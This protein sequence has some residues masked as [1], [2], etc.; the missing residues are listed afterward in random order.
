MW[1][2]NLI[3]YRF[4]QPFTLSSEQLNEKLSEYH[5][6]PCPP[7]ATHT[8]G[9][10]SPLKGNSEQLVHNTNGCF[11]LNLRKEERILPATVVNE[12]LNEKVENI[13]H[14]QNRKVRRKEKLELKDEVIFE[15][16]PKAF[17]RSTW[18]YAY[19]DPN[20]HW[21]VVDASSF[22][23][24]EEFTAYLRDCIESLPLELIKAEQNISS[25]MTQWV[26]D[27]PPNN[28]EVGTECELRGIEDEA[29]VTRCKGQ[30]L[31][32]E[33]IYSHINSGKQVTKLALSWDEKI[34]FVLCAD[35]TIKRLKFADLL[36]EQA[37]DE[38]DGDAA[39]QFDADFAILNTET[40]KLINHLLSTFKPS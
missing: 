1:F 9:W 28:I 26:Q 20:N 15:L 37:F 6:S 4:T 34:D 22:N 14:Q 29:N 36:Q 21:L 12:E 25:I 8:F 40:A 33:E 13:E 31:S 23:K 16:L 32:S 30:D 35:L 11:M 3:V 39:A 38:S 10:S 5:F 27:L 7:H 17:T 24:A 2:K 19:I 18:I